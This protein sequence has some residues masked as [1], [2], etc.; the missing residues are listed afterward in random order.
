MMDYPLTIQHLL[1]RT[2]R[3]YGKKEIVSWLPNGFHR[4]TYA[5]FYRRVQ[6]L[7]NVLQRLG[8]RKGDRVGTFAWNHYRH[9]ELYFAITCT[10]A[11]LHT[12]NIRLF[13]EQI[14]YILNHAEDTVLFFDES[15]ASIL[16][17][18]QGELKTVQH[19]VA[20]GE[21]TTPPETSLRPVHSYEALLAEASPEYRWPRLDE[22]DAAGICYT[23]G[24]TGHPKGV[25]YSHRAIFLH[26]LALTGVD[27]IGVSERETIMP[28]VPMFHV[29]AWGLPFSAAMV[30]SKQVFP[31]PH[32]KPEEL[33]YL[34]QNERVTL[35]AGVPT[36]WIGIQQ[37]LEKGGYDVSSLHTILSGG[38]AVPRS[39][40]ETF[41]RR[42]G[43]QIIH[44]WGMTEMTPVGT[45]S[46]LKSYMHTWTEEERFAVR[47]KQGFMVPGVELTAI[48]ETGKEVPWDGKTPGELLVR[49][50]WIARAYYKDPDSEEKFAGGWLHTGD[51]V[52]IDSE[53]Y[54]QIV[55]R[56]KDL[57]KSGGEWI[58]SVDL[59]TAIM[60]HPKVLEAAVI[61]IPHP[62]WQE[63]P[64]ACV[65][66]KPEYRGELSKEEIL[67]FLQDKFARWWLPDDVVFIAEIPKT[68]V[69]KFDKKVLRQ[70]FANYTLP[71]QE[72]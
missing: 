20:M 50:P 24:T 71:G 32:M 69:G 23:S 1:E 63:R 13:P 12:V 40:L 42:W 36:L 33:A 58:S 43:I 62:K 29:N 70:Q 45:V 19:F 55:D 21:G 38:S 35:A 7:A 41:E 54:I 68:S 18:I 66:P 5:D 27:C 11:V 2:H 9:L 57:V 51:V 10:G 31:G 59:E 52:T 39:L 4:Y 72:G 16:E 46:R 22:Y 44:A 30:G 61:A 26:S 14:A 60:A 8:V 65:V 64:L 3:L 48:D 15:L 25:V 47:A 56:V 53:G 49:G 67:A 17:G 34:I 6:R 28:V 37:V